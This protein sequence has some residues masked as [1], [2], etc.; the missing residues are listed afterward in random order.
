[1]K[2]H[3]MS[4]WIAVSKDLTPVTISNPW[5]VATSIMIHWENGPGNCNAEETLSNVI[6]SLIEAIVFSD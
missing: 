5:E 3:N 2:G 1:M 4:A 6:L